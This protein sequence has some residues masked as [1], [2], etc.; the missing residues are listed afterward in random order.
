MTKRVAPREIYGLITKA[1]RKGHKLKVEET[2]KKAGISVELWK[3]IE[4]GKATLEETINT[5]VPVSSTLGIDADVF[6]Y[7]VLELILGSLD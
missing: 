4:D 5:I 6:S 7:I 2:A 1:V 3:K